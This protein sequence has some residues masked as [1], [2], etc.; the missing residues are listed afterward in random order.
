MGTSA[1]IYQAFVYMT[2]FQGLITP[3]P[4]VL[5]LVTYFADIY[6]FSTSAFEFSRAQALIDIFAVDFIGTIDTVSDAITLP[7]AMDA[8]AIL[9]LK[10]VRSASSRGTV[11]L[12]T[13]VLAVRV[14]VTSPLL[15][16]ALARAALDF[17]GW[18]LGVYNWLAATLLQG[19]IRLVGA[20]CIIITYPADGDAGGGAALELMDATGWRG[21]VQLITAIAAVILAI[22]YKVPG[23]AAATGAGEL[24]GATCYIATVFFIFSTVTII[25][26]ITSPGHWDTLSRMGATADFIYAACSHMALFWAFI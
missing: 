20:V 24:T 7:A 25:F 9:T 3:V 18:T 26:T 1:I 6:A 8:A 14:P 19:L 23:D 16:D 11:D 13:A 10:L 17:A 5:L 4:A 15:M 22:A 21:T 2:F 12:I